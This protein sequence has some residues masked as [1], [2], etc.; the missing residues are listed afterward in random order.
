MSDHEV[1]I[2][3]QALQLTKK[4]FEKALCLNTSLF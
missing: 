4:L 1:K 3:K 2:T